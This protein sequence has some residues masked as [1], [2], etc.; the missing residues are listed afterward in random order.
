MEAAK[1]RI[2]APA[3]QWRAGL[4][5][6]GLL[7]GSGCSVPNHMHIT[8]GVAPQNVDLNVRFRTTYYFR[9]FD[10]CWQAKAVLD[11]GVAYRDIIPETDTIYRYR[12]TGKASALGSQIK[13]ESGTLDAAQIDP[14]GS[15]A[16]YN[17]DIGGYLVRSKEVA[18]QEADQ[19]SGRRAADGPRRDALAR[20]DRLVTLHE[21]V[22]KR[23]APPGVNPDPK[24]ALLEGIEA[25]MAKALD[26]YVGTLTG[27]LST[28]DHALL[29][30]MSEK[31]AA[32]EKKMTP[33]PA[34]A[35]AAAASPTVEEVAT[36]AATKATQAAIAEIKAQIDRRIDQGDT[37]RPLGSQC[38]SG[39][40][41]RKGFQIMGPEGMQNFDQDK[42]LILA[43]HTSAKPLIE[44]LQEY[45]SR[46][47]K[48]K[49]NPAEQLLPLVRENMRVIEAGRAMDRVALKAAGDSRPSVTEVFDAA[50]LAYQPPEKAK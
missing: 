12:M 31:L 40:I 23:P 1:N 16:V 44:T 6:A 15:D 14:F 30:A 17:A 27:P 45:S 50:L 37:A 46:V 41:A 34:V 7:L 47:I 48:G 9:V 42:R 32:I 24:L 49:A 21:E 25:A 43:M 4:A 8:E 36:A 29:T 33:A 18:E 19:A 5:L 38:P 26:I 39:G 13:F 3:G 2:S 35:A 28:D 11:G 10:F 22:A 20:Y